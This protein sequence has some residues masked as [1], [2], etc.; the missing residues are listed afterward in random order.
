MEKKN[1]LLE[2]CGECAY[3][4]KQLASKDETRATSYTEFVLAVKD[5]CN[6]INLECAKLPSVLTMSQSLKIY[7][8]LLL[9]AVRANDE[10]T[11][12][13]GD[14]LNA[15]KRV[16]KQLCHCCTRRSLR[17]FISGQCWRV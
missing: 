8:Q 12:Q 10:G 1:K 16:A 14:L 2:C 6:M 13:L 7:A 9:E 11:A 17:R 15:K 3:E 5:L 4:I